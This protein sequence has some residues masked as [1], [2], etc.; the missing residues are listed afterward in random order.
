MLPPDSSRAQQLHRRLWGGVATIITA[1]VLV[2]GCLAD[3]RPSFAQNI[4]FPARP[5]P[6]PRAVEQPGAQEQMLVR[7]EEINYDYTNEQVAAIG[8]V[9]IYYGASTL[10]AD[11]VVYDQKAKRLRAEGNVRLTQ[12]DGTVTYGEIMD[13]QRRLPRRLRRFA[14]ARR[15]RADAICRRPRR[16]VSAAATPSSRAASTPPA[17]PARTIRAS[18]RY[19]R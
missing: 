1:T 17:S 13:L 10:E 11:K 19:G 4:A 14:A 6:I 12:A 8:N 9:Q 2:F 16:S 5:K 7:A 18:R 15:P 3:A